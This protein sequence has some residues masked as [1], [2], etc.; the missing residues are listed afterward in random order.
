M[1]ESAEVAPG[2]AGRPAKLAGPKA[3][4]QVLVQITIALYRALANETARCYRDEVLGVSNKLPHGDL[5]ELAAQL[6]LG[7]DNAPSRATLRAF[8]QRIGALQRGVFWSSFY[9]G[10]GI[11]ARVRSTLWVP[12]P[13]PD[14]GMRE[15]VALS[16]AAQAFQVVSGAISYETVKK[17][18]VENESALKNEF[19]LDLKDAANALVGLAAG[20]LVGAAALFAQN[21]ALPGE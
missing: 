13:P 16:T 9:F 20:G 6:Q 19:K 11:S 18:S 14:Q 12:N 4:E 5:V 7:L 3:G 2:H 8:W 1:A 17:E 15:L 10:A 21:W